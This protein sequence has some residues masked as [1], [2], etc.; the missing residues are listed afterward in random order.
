LYGYDSAGNMTSMTRRLIT[1]PTTSTDYISTY[2]YDKLGR[3]TAAVDPRGSRTEY[4]YDDENR[5][6]KVR[7]GVVPSTTLVLQETKYEYDTLDRLTKQTTGCC[8]TTTY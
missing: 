8:R 2:E 6:T 4:Q 3:R 1:S 5:L 7:Y